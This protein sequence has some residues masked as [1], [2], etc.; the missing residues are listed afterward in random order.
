M[1]TRRRALLAALLGLAALPAWPAGTPPLML[2]STYP[3]GLDP[4]D[5]WISEKLDGVRARWDGRQLVS[6]GGHAIAAPAWFTA[7]WPAVPLDGELWGGRGRFEQT[8]STVRRQVPD[9]DTWRALR[10]MVFDLPAH[11]G[12]FTQRLQ[13]LQALLHPTPGAPASPWLRAVP[14]ARGTTREALTRQLQDIVRAGGEGLMLHRGGATYRQGR[15]ADLLKLKPFD[16]AEALVIGH[17][18]GKGKYAGQ[19]GALRVRTPDGREFRLGSGLSDALRRD[20]P[21]PGTWVTYRHQGLTDRGQPRFARFLRIR[22]DAA[23]NGPAQ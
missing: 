2:A 17:E 4:A 12:T 5:Y 20:P 8:V 21:P 16:D 22:S 9:D 1:D 23:L 15:S 13:A 3:Q 18:P 6:R 11:E 7:G 10:F 14:Q 19:L